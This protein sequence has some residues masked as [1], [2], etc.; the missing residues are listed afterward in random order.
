MK[1]SF[2]RVIATLNLFQGKQSLTI[3]LLAA[4]FALCGCDDSSSASSNGPD[5]NAAV[6]SSSSVCKD[7]EDGDG[8]SSSAKKIE[9]SDEKDVGTS[10]DAKSNSSSSSS[11]KNDTSSSS[12]RDDSLSSS[13]SYVH[14]RCNENERD[15]VVKDWGVKY[16]RCENNDWVL[17]TTIYIEKPKEYPVMDSLFATEYEPVYSEFEDP[18]DH[19]VYKT[20]ILHLR[21]DDGRLVDDVLI[22]VFAQN[23]NYGEM[24]DTSIKIHDDTKVE[25]YCDLNDEWFCNNGWGGRYTWSEAMALS[26]KYD[27]VLWKDTVGGDT[28]IH[29][30]LCP[31][32]WHIMNAYEWKN[33]TS[34]AGEDLASKVNWT[35][36]KQYVNST[37]MSVLY[38]MKSYR[39]NWGLATFHYPVERDSSWIFVEDLSENY[40]K[41]SSTAVKNGNYFYVRC[42]RDY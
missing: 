39:E 35:L 23:L 14:I 27:S 18:R 17:D 20:T 26:A 6:D 16:Y 19:Q 32:G 22:E 2:Q 10:S 31:E 33:F 3:F 7:C 15:T 34:S 28:R 21:G 13:S 9:S 40:A 11:K 30:G 36:N 41:H 12:K 25:K 8:S 38:Q 42:V 4:I 1:K 5:E 37:G 29:Q 24:I